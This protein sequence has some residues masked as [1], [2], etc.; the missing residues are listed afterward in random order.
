MVRYKD[1]MATVYTK[2]EWHNGQ[3]ERRVWHECLAY[4]ARLSTIQSA[5]HP[6]LM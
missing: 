2:V 1:I 4:R 5:S 3:Y 6:H